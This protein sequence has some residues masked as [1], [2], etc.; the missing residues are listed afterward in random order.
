M[1]IEHDSVAAIYD[2]RSSAEEAILALAKSTFD[3]RNVSV[4]GRDNSTEE[5]VVGF[6]NPG[7]RMDVWARTGA[8]WGQLSGK[9]CGSALFVIPRFGTLFAAGPLVGRVIH[10]LEGKT[11]NEGMNILGAGL[12]SIGIPKL[13]IES[14]EQQL[15][16]GKFIVI[17]HGAPSAVAS[18]RTILARSALLAVRAH[19]C[20]A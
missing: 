19:E 8:F 14:F 15:R 2:N 11:D 17:A 3:M 5:V 4:I 1:T 6:L 13:T 7:D 12:Y 16:I 10:A 9:L 18:S 20:C